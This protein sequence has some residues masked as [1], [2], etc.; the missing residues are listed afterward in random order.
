MSRVG[1]F[2]LVGAG[3][4]FVLPH[5]GCGSTG[6]TAASPTSMPGVS[7]VG[8]TMVKTVGAD[9]EG[10]VGYKFADANLG[11]EWLI[12]TLAVTGLRGEAIEISQEAI[13]VRTPDGRSI[14]LPT[15]EEFIEA[16]PET[17]SILRRAA[18]AREPLEATRGGRQP[19]ALAFQRIPGTGTTQKSV[20]VTHNQLCVGMLSFPVRGGVQPGRWKLTIE[21][22]ESIFEIPFDIEA[23]E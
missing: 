23:P 8:R 4:L 1:L 9:L 2:S 19:C 20:W 14:A 17:Q 15:Q 6:N 3:A 5:F 18:I 10:V 16:Y 11:E 13:S 12:I 22:E 21:F 7:Q